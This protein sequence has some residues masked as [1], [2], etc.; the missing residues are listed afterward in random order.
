MALNCCLPRS[1]KNKAITAMGF[2]ELDLATFHRAPGEKPVFKSCTS[3]DSNDTGVVKNAMRISTVIEI[4]DVSY[5]C[6]ETPFVGQL[7]PLNWQTAY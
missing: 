5:L 2:C 7:A 1:R 4:E 6:E 3:L